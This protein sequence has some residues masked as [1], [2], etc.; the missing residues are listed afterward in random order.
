MNIL[1]I[2]PLMSVVGSK[3]AEIIIVVKYNKSPNNIATIG[4]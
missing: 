2:I 1:N 4:F 3:I